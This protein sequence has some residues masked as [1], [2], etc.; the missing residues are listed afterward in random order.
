MGR[1]RVV[2]EVPIEQIRCWAC[3]FLEQASFLDGE[4]RLVPGFRCPQNVKLDA[5]MPFYFAEKCARFR[6]AR[7]ERANKPQRG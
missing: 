5:R 3:S 4:G 1:T 7:S 2:V 6:C